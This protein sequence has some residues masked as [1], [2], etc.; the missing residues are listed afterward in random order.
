MESTKSLLEHEYSLK[1][2]H[3]LFFIQ[4]E[5]FHVVLKI[6]SNELSSCTLFN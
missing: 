2:W 6:F 1:K 5:I 4:Q 3:L